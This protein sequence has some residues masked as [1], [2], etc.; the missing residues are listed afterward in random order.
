[1]A[2][3]YDSSLSTDKDKVRFLIQDTVVASA[4]LQDEE[5]TFMLTEYDDYHL[6]SAACADVLS[7]KFAS[8]ADKKTVG[9]LSITYTNRSKTYS[10]LAKQ[11]RV[12]SVVPYAGGVDLTVSV[13][14][15]D[16]M[17]FGRGF[18]DFV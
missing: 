5:I 11:L 4:M 9:K 15:D 10:D 8:M 14:S 16:T 2:A 1:M 12:Q 7:A 3:T 17:A 6:A 18:M 13:D